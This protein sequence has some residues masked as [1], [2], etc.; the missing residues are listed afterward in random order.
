VSARCCRYDPTV[1]FTLAGKTSLGCRYETVCETCTFFATTIEF[2]D[3]L[4]AQQADAERH[5]DTARQVTYLKI[6]DTLDD[7]GT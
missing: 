1:G 2:R 4:K 5:G 3:H 7:T 6:L